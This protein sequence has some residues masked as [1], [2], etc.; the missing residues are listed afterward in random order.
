MKKDPAI[1]AGPFASREDAV[2]WC[3]A[4]NAKYSVFHTYGRDPEGYLDTE[5][6]EYF[7]EFNEFGDGL[8]FGYSPEEIKRKQSK[9]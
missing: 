4:G 5:K 8:I 6:S 9:L 1:I 2:S 7:V 3:P